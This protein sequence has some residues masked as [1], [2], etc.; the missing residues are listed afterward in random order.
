MEFCASSVWFS[1]GFSCGCAVLAFSCFSRFISPGGLS[2]VYRSRE[3]AGFLFTPAAVQAQTPIR[4][5]ARPVAASAC[6]SASFASAAAA[7][8]RLHSPVSDIRRRQLML[9]KALVSKN[10]GKLQ[11]RRK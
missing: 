4:R 9:V 2:R 6:A 8:L 10:G 11:W 1:L 3:G 5:G 7:A